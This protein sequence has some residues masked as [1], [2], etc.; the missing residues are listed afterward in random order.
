MRP[1][2]RRAAL[3]LALA[4]G[5]PVACGEPPRPNVLLIVIDTSRADRFPFNGYD[6]PTTPELLRLSRDGAVYRHVTSPGSWTVPA[7]ASLFTGQYPSMHGTDCG[8]LLLPDEAVT[9]A[10]TFRAAGY[11][12]VA[13]TANP[14]ISTTYHFQQGFDVFGETWRLVTADSED[15]G[16]ALTNEQALRF[17]RFRQDDPN[18][19]RQPFFLFLNYFEPHL[20]YHPPEPE[21]SRFVRPG[22]DP[23]RVLRLSR[24][25]TPEETLRF[26]LGLSEL[27]ATDLGILSDLYDG[28]IAY[29]DR[30]LGEVIALLRAQGIL[31]ETIVAVTSDHGE[32]LGEHHLMD[33]KMSVHDTVLQVPLVLR[34]PARVAAGQRI[35]AP[36]QMHDLFPT[37]LGL[38][39]IPLP[40]GTIVEAVPLP[41]AGLGGARRSDADPIVGEFAGP[42]VEFLKTMED[43]FP[44][45]DLSRFNRTLVSL[46]LGGYTILWGSDGRHALYRTAA[47]PAQEHDLAAAE[48]ERLGEMVQAVESW[49][50]RAARNRST[51]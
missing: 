27:D 12:T 10:E 41:G 37:L 24:F 23:S 45:A 13:Y 9:L 28:E 39:D 50:G 18:A 17:L 5:L 15:T 11:R 48:P 20:P 25:G 31:D 22:S 2:L 29:A 8:F 7:H 33:H 26:V 47:D 1:V 3:L 35:D 51:P 32:N 4:A 6:R 19:R 21:R 49:R 44:Q 40:G 42:P 43:L 46:R 30:R 38:A 14:W 36:V 34:Y 16:A